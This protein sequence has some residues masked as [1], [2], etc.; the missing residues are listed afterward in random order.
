[1]Q[2]NQ[3]PSCPTISHPFTFLLLFIVLSDNSYLNQ[4]LPRGNRKLILSYI[5]L[6]FMC[7]HLLYSIP[8]SGTPRS[9]LRYKTYSMLCRQVAHMPV[10]LR[11]PSYFLRGE[12][13]LVPKFFFDPTLMFL[14]RVPL[15]I[16]PF[17][18]LCFNPGNASPA[19]AAEPLCISSSGQALTFLLLSS[20]L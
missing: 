18:L 20:V 16:I 3:T 19:R 2:S 1:M 9:P 8:I 15:F 17:F 5:G 6:Y 11:R 7:L 12:F 4:L 14:A 13:N 10:Y